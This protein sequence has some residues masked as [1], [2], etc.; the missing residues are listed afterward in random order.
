MAKNQTHSL[1]IAQATS[2]GP[3]LQDSR[4]N[5]QGGR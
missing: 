3:D 4:F 1:K 2:T 5:S